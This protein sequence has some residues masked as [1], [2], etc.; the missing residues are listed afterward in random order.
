MRPFTRTTA[1]G[2]FVGLAVLT[3]CG[4]TDTTSAPASPGPSP[5][6]SAQASFPVTVSSGGASTTVE[7]EPRAIVSL[8]PTATEM[9]YAVDA[10]PQVKAVDDQSSYPS[11]APRTK[12]S[13]F[14]PNVEAL[15]AT[16]PDLVLLSDASTGDVGAGLAKAGVPYLVLPAATTLQDTYDQI[17]AIGTATG[18]ADAAEELVAG[19]KS[20][21][22][23]LVAE[24][25]Q[26][27]RK[28]TY[29]HELD[30]TYFSA[31]SKTFLGQLYGLAGLTNIAD[32]ADS[33]GKAGGY[34][35]L[36]AEYI[37]KA[38]P[39]LIFLAD[40]K[41]CDVTPAKLAARPGFSTLTA[42]KT[43]QVVPLPEDVA[44]R[45]G[46]RVV[47]LLR[48][49]VKATQQLDAPSPAPSSTTG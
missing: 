27:E 8:S 10:G 37:V 45:W 19:M 22:D 46:P 11:A 18:H 21:I 15:L 6:P 17:A 14:Q 26:R 41:C 4:T 29:Y 5:S 23:A 9:V 12:L 34:P 32:E 42:V 2:A 20:D 25:P 30:P 49:I 28:P 33:G 7:R 47:E 38:D 13:G 31:T 48:V 35:Q 43:G 44:S 39:D 3:A 1:L 24:V 36:S 16:S 40:E